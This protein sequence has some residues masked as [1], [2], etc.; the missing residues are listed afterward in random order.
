MKNLC[1]ESIKNPHMNMTFPL[2]KDIKGS[3]PFSVVKS[4]KFSIQKQQV[5]ITISHS[6]LI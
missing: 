5:Y 1:I 3:I 6:A 2:S 4:Q